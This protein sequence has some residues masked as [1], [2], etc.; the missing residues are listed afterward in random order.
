MAKVTIVIEDDDWKTKFS[1]EDPNSD[2]VTL[3]DYAHRITKHSLE[4]GRDE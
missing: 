2:P 1:E 3:L 4:D